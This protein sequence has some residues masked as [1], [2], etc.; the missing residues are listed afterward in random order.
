MAK[1]IEFLDQPATQKG[2]AD[3]VGVS[4]QAVSDK[5]EKAG[6][7]T[8][9]TYRQWLV[10]YCEHFRQ[11]AA[12]RGAADDQAN[13]ARAKTREST[14]NAQLKELQF[15]KEVGTLVPVEDLEPLLE[16]WVVTA[17]SETTY[18]VEKLV[19]AI[20]SKH[21]IEVEQVLIDDTLGAAFTSI[22][23]HP[24]NLG[25]VAGSGSEE[26]ATT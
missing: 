14:A 21:N 18:A 25:G 2:F 13:A 15:H 20:Q 6:L 19:A 8:G 23:G 12:G 1:K 24:R 7:R 3:L 9:G 4:Q 17:R 16:S 10:S 5:V 26:V 22:A 11:L